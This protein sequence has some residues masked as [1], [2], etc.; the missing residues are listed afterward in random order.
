[1]LPNI[2]LFVNRGAQYA[3]QGFTQSHTFIS[4]DNGIILMIIITI[5]RPNFV[6]PVKQWLKEFTI[7]RK[8]EKK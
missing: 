6:W 7:S 2:I 8:P 3:T 1:M 4:A 5:S